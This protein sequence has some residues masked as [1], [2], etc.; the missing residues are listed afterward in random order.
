MVE[1]SIIELHRHAIHQSSIKLYHF[2]AIIFSHFQTKKWRK[3]TNCQLRETKSIFKRWNHRFLK[4]LFSLERLYANEPE[5][6]A[7]DLPF[8][9]SHAEYLGRQRIL[10][11]SIG[12]F[13][14]VEQFQTPISVALDWAAEICKM[15]PN[16]RNWQRWHFWFRAKYWL[17]LTI[18]IISIR[19]EFF[20]KELCNK[21]S[22]D[23]FCDI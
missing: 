23:H 20:K 2:I 15:A 19:I 17:T 5:Y 14:N 8:F 21:N 10:T 18:Y 11:T 16:G 9:M 13:R 6:Y 1:S 22:A 3:L 12:I 7:D 4:R